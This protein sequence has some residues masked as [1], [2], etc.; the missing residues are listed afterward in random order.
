M[1]NYRKIILSRM[2]M[3]R[4]TIPLMKM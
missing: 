2:I 1:D 4:V 3:I